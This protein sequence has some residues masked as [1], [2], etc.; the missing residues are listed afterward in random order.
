MTMIDLWRVCSQAWIER[1]NE[2]IGEKRGYI[3]LFES[4]NNMEYARAVLDEALKYLK[5]WV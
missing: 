4:E 5:T 2:R 3:S 1:L